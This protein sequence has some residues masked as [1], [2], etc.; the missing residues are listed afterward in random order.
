[1]PKLAC[2]LRIVQMA[3][4][5]IKTR[6]GVWKLKPRWQMRWAE[7]RRVVKVYSLGPIIISWWSNENMAKHGY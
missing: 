5:Q 3:W 1:M 4:A 6:R 7:K 2:N